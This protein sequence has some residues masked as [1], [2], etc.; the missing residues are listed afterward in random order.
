[1]ESSSTPRVILAS[2]SPRRRE[3]LSRILSAFEVRPARIDEEA[4]GAG[5]PNPEAAALSSALAKARAVALEAPDALVI[6]CDTVVILD[7]EALGK[8][9][10]A[11]D[12]VRMVLALGGRMHEVATGVALLL[13]SG[14][15]VP[16]EPLTAV[17]VTEV[18][19]RP[20]SE[21]LARAYVAQ[22]ES[23][24]KAGAYGIQGRGSLLVERVEG[25][26]HNVVG[27]PLHRLGRMLEA[28]GLGPFPP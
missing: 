14:D 27:L 15:G 10:D 25:C 17:E 11:E 8:P 5:A 26:Y 13:P 22:G 2:E 1:L 6:G 21:S 12:A 7:G 23:L 24:D 20:V 4:A 18:A 3:L 16:A 28:A 19:F 9:R